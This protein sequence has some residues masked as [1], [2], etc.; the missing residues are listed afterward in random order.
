MGSPGQPDDAVEVEDPRAAGFGRPMRHDH[1]YLRPRAS[2]GGHSGSS[3]RRNDAHRWAF[4][5]LADGLGCSPKRLERAQEA[6]VLLDSPPHEP[7]TSP[8]AGTKLIEAPVVA[9]PSE[10]VTLHLVIGG[11]G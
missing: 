8:A 3:W 7:R 10:G 1:H 9:N 11:L 6:S 4:G 5:G 2:A